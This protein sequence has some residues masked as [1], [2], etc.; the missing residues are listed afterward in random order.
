MSRAPGSLRLSLG[1]PLLAGVVGGA[2]AYVGGYALSFAILILDVILDGGGSPG[3]GTG[4]ESQVLDVVGTLYTEAHFLPLQVDSAR[5]TEPYH[6]LD[7][8]NLAFPNL[9]YHLVP[10]AVLLLAGFLVASRVEPES[11]LA[12]A[13]AGATV[14]LAYLP[15]VALGAGTFAWGGEIFGN[16]FTISIPLL[17]AVVR[18][19]LLYPL[20]LGS[21]GGL[22]AHEVATD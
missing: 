13:R 7:T 5:G 14:V 18:A 9:V 16:A 11:R 17:E 12:G 19:G 21:V 1:L 20:L 10:V 8:V 6:L 4:A 3:G 22:A 15:L 2:L